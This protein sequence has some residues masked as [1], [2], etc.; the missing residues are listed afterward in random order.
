MNTN[1]VL[2]LVAILVIFLIFLVLGTDTSIEQFLIN[3]EKLALYQGTPLPL[4]SQSGYYPMYQKSLPSTD[5]TND[6]RSMFA[7]AYN[8][9]RP[10]CCKDTPYSC[11]T[12]CPCLN[13]NQKNLL[14]S[15]GGNS[16]YNTKCSKENTTADISGY[17]LGFFNP[18]PE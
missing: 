3:P 10:E 17:G 12:G 14:G 2:L 16:H 8:E 1:F 9:C 6:N 4:D 18:K 15:R 13:D 7:F 5:G 11:S